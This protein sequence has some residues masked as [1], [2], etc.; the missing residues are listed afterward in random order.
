MSPRQLEPMSQLLGAVVRRVLELFDRGRV[1]FQ[2]LPDQLGAARGY[3]F[4][5]ESGGVVCIRVT[6]AK[7]EKLQL[8]IV[9]S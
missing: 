8:Y 9:L 6:H 3:H 5:V 4:D 1:T 2:S 7:I